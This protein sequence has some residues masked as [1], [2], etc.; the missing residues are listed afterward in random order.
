MKTIIISVIVCV[1]LVLIGY[2]NPIR[3]IVISCL[4]ACSFAA[5]CLIYLID[6]ITDKIYDKWHN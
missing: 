2:Y 5:L 1:V 3:L 4:G 6:Y